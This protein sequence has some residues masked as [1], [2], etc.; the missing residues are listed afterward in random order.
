MFSYNVFN[1]LSIPLYGCT[2]IYVPNAQGFPISSFWF[3]DFINGA[4]AMHPDSY[5]FMPILI[6]FSQQILKSSLIQS[7]DYNI[8]LKLK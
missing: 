1:V 5:I 4:L 3:V 6:I 7:N 2:I 8:S